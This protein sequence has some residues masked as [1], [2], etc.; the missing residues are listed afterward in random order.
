MVRTYRHGTPLYLLVNELNQKLRG[1]A[2]HHRVTTTQKAF[3]EISEHLFKIIW[4]MLRKLHSV[5]PRRL[6]SRQYFTQ[7]DGNNWIFTCD[8]PLESDGD[9]LTLFQIAYVPIL[10]HTLC[11]SINPY[12]PDNYEY[13]EKRIARSATR[14][15]GQGRIRTKLLTKQKGL[16]PVCGLQLLNDERIEVHHIKP[17]KEGGSDKPRNLMLLHKVCHLQV[18][19]PNRK[20]KAR[21]V[22]LGIIKV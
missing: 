1:W 17:R 8:P 21:W 6:L 22:K 11:K 7:R 15:L 13:F 2:E 16:C 10:R 20:Q 5:R 4:K 3:N 18:T 14:S 19:H 12:D 9:K